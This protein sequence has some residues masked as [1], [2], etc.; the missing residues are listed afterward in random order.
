MLTL[1]PHVWLVTRVVE[2]TTKKPENLVLDVKQK[3]RGGLSLDPDSQTSKPCLPSFRDLP[4]DHPFGLPGKSPLD[5]VVVEHPL[6]VTGPVP[7][8]AGGSLGQV[9]EDGIARFSLIQIKSNAWRVRLSVQLA[10]ISMA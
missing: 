6:D 2:T 4:G 1:D 9:I 3:L 10:W 8:D 7:D 5:E